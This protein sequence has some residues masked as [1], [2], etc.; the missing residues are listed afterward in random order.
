[1]T[2]TYCTDTY[3]GIIDGPVY[4]TD[5]KLCALLEPHIPTE[6]DQIAEFRRELHRIA[7]GIECVPL[8][9]NGRFTVVNGYSYKR[10]HR[11][12]R[13][14]ISHEA[15]MAGSRLTDEVRTAYF[16]GS[17]V[18]AER[19]AR[20]AAQFDPATI[21]WYGNQVMANLTGPDGQRR[22]CVD[23][24]SDSVLVIIGSYCV[25]CPPGEEEAE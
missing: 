23:P 14:R 13:L 17:R 3:A 4:T 18:L 19:V 9:A 15:V 22:I 21:R 16:D 5:P 20:D 25:I 2:D 6:K 12:L 24:N 10:Q 7:P 11:Y 1:M 8:G